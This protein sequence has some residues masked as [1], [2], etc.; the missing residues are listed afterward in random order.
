[1]VF[2]NTFILSTVFRSN[3]RKI[4]MDINVSRSSEYKTTY[5]VVCLCVWNCQNW[6]T[7]YSRNSKFG[8]LHLYHTRMLLETFYEDW[9]NC[10]CTR[11]HINILI[12]YGLWT[13]FLVVEILC[14]W[15]ALS[16]MKL[17]CISDKF[18]DSMQ[19]TKYDM[20]S[21]HNWSRGPYKRMQIRS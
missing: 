1:M 11:V 14:I 3:I 4:L 5:S 12:H 20:N 2:H 6:K 13:E 16:R 7:S 9:I 21:A 8:I 17:T 19:P 15:T 10:L 18:K